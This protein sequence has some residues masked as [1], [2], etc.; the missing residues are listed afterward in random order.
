MRLPPLAEGE[1][2]IGVSVAVPDPYRGQLAAARARFGDPAARLV[3]PHV[4]LLGPTRVHRDDLATVDD[5]LTAVAVRH[6][7]F[8]LRLVGAATFRPVSPV[9]F[10]QVVEGGP[11]C[12]AL[13][14]GLRTGPLAQELRFEYHPHVTV[15]QGV[16]DDLLDAAQTGMDDYVAEFSV[17]SFCRYEHG[18]DGLWRPARTFALASVPPAG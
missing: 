10:V 7:R 14:A 17:T 12:A 1:L 9:T 5:H 18:T 11:A 13:A 6:Q 8:D 15:A 2:W 4:T 3:P 16:D